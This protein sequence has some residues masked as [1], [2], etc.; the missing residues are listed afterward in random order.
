L[1]SD[2]C[3]LKELR[4]FP[5]ISR[6]FSYVESFSLPVA[7]GQKLFF[8]LWG[9]ENALPLPALFMAFSEWSGFAASYFEDV[10]ITIEESGI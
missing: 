4:C 7:F 1:V 3:A 5:G 10:R 8:P 2:V 9:V 6:A